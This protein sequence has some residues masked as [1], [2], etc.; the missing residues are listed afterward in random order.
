MRTFP[1]ESIDMVIFSPP[2]FNLRDYDTEGQIG[3]EDTVKKYIDNMINVCNE[4][5]RIIKQTG[6]M[7]IVIGD[8]YH[9]GNVRL[10]PSR[11]FQSLKKNG[12]K[13]RNKIIWAKTNPMPE[14]TDNRYSKSY[15]EIGFFVKANKYYFD[16]NNVLKPFKE[17]SIERYKRP[18]YPT[19][20][21][22]GKMRVGVEGNRT[23]AKKV[24]SGEL[25]GRHPRDV[26]RIS[27]HSGWSAKCE[28]FAVYPEKLC[29]VPIKASCP[30][31]VCSK[32]G[33]PKTRMIKKKVELGKLSEDKIGDHVGVSD[34]SLFKRRDKKVERRFVGWKANCNHDSGFEAGIVLDPMCGS[35]T[36][37]KVA[38]DLGRRFIGIDLN[39]KY[40]EI[41]CKRLGL[42]N[43]E[44]VK[45][46]I[47]RCISIG[48]C[49]LKGEDDTCTSKMFTDCEYR[50]EEYV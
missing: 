19:K 43:Y 23:T 38:K 13:L 20:G 27:V 36:T 50:K 37:L 17:S 16:M 40:C 14:S 32:C 3:Q 26:W 5:Q 21:D 24:L 30:E 42:E 34:T 45:K 39:P 11:L 47:V 48:T 44:V 18:M 8:S 41:A 22:I 31:F 33:T 10:V 28:H 4:I 49:D 2:Y 29:L 1:D 46:K 12:W 25:K 6:S 7:Y 35:G 9:N 15:E